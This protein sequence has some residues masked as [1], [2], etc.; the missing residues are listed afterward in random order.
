MRQLTAQELENLRTRTEVPNQSAR[1]LWKVDLTALNQAIKE[2]E[3]THKVKI[4][5]SGGHYTI[6]T[7]RTI[8]NPSTKEY[9]HL[10]VL[11][12]NKSIE[13]Q[14][15]TLLHELRHAYQCEQ[16]VKE[17]NQVPRYDADRKLVTKTI[18][19]H[20]RDEYLDGVGYQ[21]KRHEADANEFAH[22]NHLT[23]KLLKEV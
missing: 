14:N 12:Q 23:T 11:S 1:A 5:Y 20:Y 17:W 3:L 22:N 13:T 4:R 19:D 18:K 6:G 7:H 21:H 16:Y 15:F 10:I 9:E 8:L 2:L